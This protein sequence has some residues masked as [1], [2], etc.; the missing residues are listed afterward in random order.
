MYSIM[1]SAKGDHF[2]FLFSIWFLSI[3][4]SFLIAMAKTSRTMLNNS[5]KSGYP[6][7]FPDLRGD[8]FIFLPLSITLAV[9]VSCMAFIMLR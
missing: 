1:L 3:Y 4:F 8:A 6:F 7:L 9:G 2:N 5:G